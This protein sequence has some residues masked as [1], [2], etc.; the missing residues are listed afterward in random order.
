MDTF[1]LKLGLGFAAWSVIVTI[2]VLYWPMSIIHH[3][4]SRLFCGVFICICTA[5]SAAYMYQAKTDVLVEMAN[6]NQRLMLG[7]LPKKS[8]S[9]E[10][11]EQKEYYSDLRSIQHQTDVVEI[12]SAISSLSD[13]ATLMITILG[14]CIGGGL[15]SVSVLDRFNNRLITLTKKNAYN[16][17]FK[18]DSQR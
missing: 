5:F 9:I 6:V 11:K 3:V 17:A 13:I 1:F 18:S 14:S 2:A 4:R 16:K 7:Y 15:I 10:S 12:D 8:D